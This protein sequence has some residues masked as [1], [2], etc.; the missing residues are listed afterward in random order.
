MDTATHFVIGISLAGIAHIDPV[1][2]NEALSQAVFL[3][4]IIGSQ[5][6]DFDGV[7]RLFGGTAGYIKHHRGVSHSIPAL[8]I[9]PT[10]ITF[11]ISLFYSSLTSLSHLWLWTFLAVFLHVLL[12]L[13]NAYGTQA[14]LPFSRKWVA[15]NIIH[16]FDPFI[17]L[18]HGGSAVFWLLLE[19][20]PLPVFIPVYLFSLIYIGWRAW[21]HH[22]IFRN[23][24]QEDKAVG[25]F[26]F[27]PTLSW[28]TWNF[29]FENENEF[30]MGAVTHGKLKWM[31]QKIKPV[32][33]P[34]VEAS[35]EDKKIKILLAFTPFAYPKWEKTSFG[36]EVHWI[37]LRYRFHQHYPFVAIALLDESY[38]VIDSYVGWLYH[39]KYVSKKIESLLK[40]ST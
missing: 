10:L 26:T 6:P 11:F 40:Q 18:L 38:Q 27:F 4:S 25:K 14:F 37:D 19:V 28:S 31:D 20:K 29:I 5:A 39:Q 12:D 34:S 36:Y 30:K 23:I 22:N 15:L 13:L 35:K 1:M 8:F 2:Q 24:R 16:I 17:F 32:P 3:G 21:S 9:W 33:H 7:S